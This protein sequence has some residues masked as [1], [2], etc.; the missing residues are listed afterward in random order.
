MSCKRAVNMSF[1]DSIHVGRDRG[2]DCV[3]LS[4]LFR[5]DTP[6][7][8]DALFFGEIKTVRDE[9]EGNG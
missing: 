3:P 7:I 9:N 8:M 2:L 6:A 1:R 4:A 5:G